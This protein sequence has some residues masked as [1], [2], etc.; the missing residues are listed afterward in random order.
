MIGKSVDGQRETDV[1]QREEGA[2]G[3]SPHQSPRF[4]VHVEVPAS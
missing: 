3:Q 1:N 4:V 2:E